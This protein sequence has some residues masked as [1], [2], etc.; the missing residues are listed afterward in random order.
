[1]SV[2]WRAV[3]TFIATLVCLS[4]MVW[5]MKDIKTWLRGLVA[6]IIL[7][8]TLGPLVMVW[9]MKDIENEKKP[10]LIR[11]FGVRAWVATI[12]VVL[13]GIGFLSIIINYQVPPDIAM[14]ATATNATLVENYTKYQ[15]DL[16]TIVKDLFAP[17][18]MAIV[19]FYFGSS[20]TQ[21]AFEKKEEKK[22]EQI[23]IEN[24]LFYDE[25]GKK[26]IKLS[27]RNSGD[28]EVTVDRVYINNE[29]KEI[30][31]VTISPKSA[32]DLSVEHE[33]GGGESYRIKVATTESTII[34]KEEKTP[35]KEKTSQQG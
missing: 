26:I 23:R 5:I 24:I 7:I 34:E 29:P 19:A 33:W 30:K 14:N 9:L 3:I 32:E 25:S 6:V 10:K 13:F 11:D 4:F 8:V 18:V 27:I 35:K 21:R 12:V 15:H 16:L 1:M 20:A 17:I 22:P 28:V 2:S 31:K